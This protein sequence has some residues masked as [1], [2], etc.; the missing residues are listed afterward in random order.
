[1]E[2]SQGSASNDDE[3]NDATHTDGAPATCPLLYRVPADT[4]PILAGTL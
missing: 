4:P 2:S 3:D 1:M